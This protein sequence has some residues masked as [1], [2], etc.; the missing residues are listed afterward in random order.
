MKRRLLFFV[1]L[2][3]ALAVP[4]TVRADA[5]TPLMWASALHL[6]VGNLLVGL[7]EGCLLTWLFAVPARR[8]LWI[9]ILAN[10]FSAWIGVFICAAI[11]RALPMD[12][13]NGWIWFWVM[14]VVTYGMTLVLEW[15]FIA[16]CFRGTQGW[17]RRSVRASLVVQSVSYV[18]LFGWYSMASGTS[19]YTKMHVVAPADLSLPESVLVYFISPTDGSVYRRP[20]VGGSEKKV[21]DLHSTNDND[22]LFARPCKNDTECW[23]LVARLEMKN[24]RDVRFVDVLTDMPVEAAADRG[25]MHTDPPLYEGTGFTFGEAQP[26]GNATDSH[27]EFRAGF[28]AGEGLSAENKTTGERVGFSYETPFGAWVVRNAVHLPSDKVLFQLGDN[29]ICAFDPV[30]RR[31]ALLWHGRG[32]VAVIEKTKPEEIVRHP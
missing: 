18:L 32:P 10:Y 22:R 11:V 3:G 20:L 13:N 14:V 2:A 27:W 19:L 9:M 23:D 25:S 8:S 16:L 12:L 1:A 29:Q 5:G 30:T 24:R 28:W 6:L 21:F 7:G 17:L 31:V 15:P 26:L 4:Q